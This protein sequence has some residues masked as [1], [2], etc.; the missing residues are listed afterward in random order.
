MV[1]SLLNIDK[2]VVKGNQL[3]RVTYTLLE[4]SGLNFI[5]NLEGDEILSG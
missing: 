2:E 5:G 3:T 1:Q 4:K